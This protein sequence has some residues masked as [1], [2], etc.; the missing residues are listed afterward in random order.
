[1]LSYFALK[2]FLRQ[3]TLPGPFNGQAVCLDIAGM[4]SMPFD[5]LELRLCPQRLPFFDFRKD[6]FHQVLVFYRFPRRS[7]PPVF[8]PILKPFRHT[9][10]RVLAVR[11]D[12]HSSVLGHDFQSSKDSRELGSLVRLPWPGKSLGKIPVLDRLSID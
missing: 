9:V 2:A 8:S 12:A 10:N 4:M 11:Y 5:P 3:R 7:L 6:I 1:M